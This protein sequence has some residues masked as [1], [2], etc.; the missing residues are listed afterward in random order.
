MIKLNYLYIELPKKV[1]LI[2]KS[3][4]LNYCFKPEDSFTYWDPNEE[5]NMC[6]SNGISIN[7]LFKL[8]STG[9]FEHIYVLLSEINN[10]YYYDQNH[11]KISLTGWIDL[12]QFEIGEDS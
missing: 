7:D 5:A 9:L 6:Y 3:M 8:A 1:R 10:A 11:N 4:G 2:S 12:L